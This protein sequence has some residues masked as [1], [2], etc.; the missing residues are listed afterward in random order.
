MAQ[1]RSGLPDDLSNVHRVALDVTEHR[2]NLYLQ[3][4]GIYA[5]ETSF[6]NYR[7]LKQWVIAN[8]RGM[9]YHI[10]YEREGKNSACIWEF[11]FP[12]VTDA[13]AFKLMFG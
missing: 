2:N 9:V 11:F 12:N 13:V 1:L 5:G 8:T 3:K 6:T 4:F 10:E 7:A